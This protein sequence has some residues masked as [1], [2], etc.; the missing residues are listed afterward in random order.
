MEGISQVDDME[1]TDSILQLTEQSVEFGTDLNEEKRDRKRERQ[2]KRNLFI[3]NNLY[4]S[5]RRESVLSSNVTPDLTPR[6]NATLSPRSAAMSPRE[7]GSAEG[8][9]RSALSSGINHA[10]QALENE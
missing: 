9:V 2:I 3:E 1:K 5:Q 10:I 6:A 4:R 7:T 8:S